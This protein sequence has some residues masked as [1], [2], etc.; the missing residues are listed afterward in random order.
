MTITRCPSCGSR[1]I[2]KTVKDLSGEF[3]GKPYLVADLA[4]YECPVCGERVFDREAM[5]RI[6]S[7]SPAYST[8]QHVKRTA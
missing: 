6:E 3:R 7:C 8:A 5:R 1:R 2:R 4:Y